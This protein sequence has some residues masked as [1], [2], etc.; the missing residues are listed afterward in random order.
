[1]ETVSQCTGIVI[2]IITVTSQTLVPSISLRLLLS[3]HLL[4]SL[5]FLMNYCK[6]LRSLLWLNTVSKNLNYIA[7]VL[8][9]IFKMTTLRL[10]FSLS[11]HHDFF[12]S[13]CLSMTT[14]LSPCPSFFHFSLYFSPSLSTQQRGLWE[15]SSRMECVPAMPNLLQIWWRDKGP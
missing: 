5:I 10:P 8:R 13:L 1:M 2:H 9:F 6:C 3:I 15:E 14:S 12:L 7:Q 4:N 11:L